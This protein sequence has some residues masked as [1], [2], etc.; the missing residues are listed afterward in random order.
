MNMGRTCT[1]RSHLVFFPS[2]HAC[3][4]MNDRLKNHVNVPTEMFVNFRDRTVGMQDRGAI[5]R[6]DFMETPTPR[7]T[8][9]R[10]SVEIA[11]LLKKSFV[12]R[13]S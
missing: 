1:R 12:I 2:M 8:T 10:P 7:A 4:T 9:M 3:I 5:P 6:F 11:Y 13:P